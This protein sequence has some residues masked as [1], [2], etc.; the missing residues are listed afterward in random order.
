M[1]DGNSADNTVAI[2]K[3]YG[4]KVLSQYDTDEPE[5]SCAMDKAA[6]R[7][8]A[9]A[10]STLPWRFFMD[11]DDTLSPE[12]VEEI[13]HIVTGEPLHFI[14]RMPTRV[15]I[16][17][18]EIL[19]EAT[20]PSYQTRLVHEKVHARFKNPVH[21]HLVWDTQQYPVGTMRTFYNFHWSRERVSHYWDYL[22]GYADRELRTLS[23]PNFSA[24]LY[25]HYRRARTLAGYVFW[26]LPIMYARHGFKDTMPLLIEFTIV[27]YHLYLYVGLCLKYIRERTWVIAL[28][29]TLRGKDLNRILSNLAVRNLE[30]YGRVLDVGGGHGASYW[31]YL[32]TTRWFKKTSLDIMPQA[33]P[34]IVLDLEV[35]PIPRPDAHF[36]T[37]LL[38][39]V[40]EHLHERPLVLS[41]IRAVVKPGGALIGIVPFLVAVHPDPHDFA[42]MTNEELAI[43]FRDAGFSDVKISPVGRGPLVAS[44]YQSEF[45]WPRILKLILMPIVLGLDSFLLALRPAWRDKFPLSY[46]FVARV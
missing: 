11:S 28:S 8:R 9:M 34:D 39:N 12:T 15:F 2:A 7:E 4:A 10:A 29:E 43:L 17:N 41:R 5:T 25:Q 32:R 19:Y 1:C 44:Y 6:I 3:Q 21:D 40:L 18:R 23:V 20:Y 33:K 22:R 13:G 42:R 36:D 30:A 26:R 14:W 35:Q 46:L 24:L 31:R 27:R 37:A 16:D 45:L 38:F